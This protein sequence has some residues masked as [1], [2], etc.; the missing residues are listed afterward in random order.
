MYLHFLASVPVTLLALPPLQPLTRHLSHHICTCPIIS[1][2][3]W[4]NFFHPDQLCP[5]HPPLLPSSRCHD[6]SCSPRTPSQSLLFR[7]SAF[8]GSRKMALC[9]CL[10]LLSGWALPD[11]AQGT[12]AISLSFTP[13]ITRFWLWQTCLYEIDLPANNNWKRQIKF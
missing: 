9:L 2:C 5:F 4:F 1:A 8:S 12:A 7:M 13:S 11:A 10:A 6:P 3:I